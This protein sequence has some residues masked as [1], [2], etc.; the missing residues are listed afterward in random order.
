MAELRL[1]A[2]D[3]QDVTRWRWRLTDQ[4]GAF[5]ADHAVELGLG[6]LEYQGFVDLAGFLRDRAVP[7]RRLTSEAG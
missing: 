4:G 3:V 6:D 1:R 7:D 2:E 5:L